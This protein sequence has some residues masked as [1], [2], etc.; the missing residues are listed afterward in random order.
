MTHSKQA[1]K[2]VRQNEKRRTR[3]KAKASAM[4]TAVKRTIAAA[5]AGEAQKV[6]GDVA[7]TLAQ[8][9]K[10]AKA[11]VIGKNTAARRKSRVMRAVAK[12]RG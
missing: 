11:K 4:K 8:I 2:R 3:N 6:E 10:A 7:R 9:D 1:A 12:A 5:E